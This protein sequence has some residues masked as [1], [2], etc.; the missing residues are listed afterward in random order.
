MKATTARTAA[1][2]SS[3][4][5][6]PFSI[7]VSSSKSLLAVPRLAPRCSCPCPLPL[8][9]RPHVRRRSTETGVTSHISLSL[10]PVALRRQVF[11]QFF[12]RGFLRF[13]TLTTRALSVALCIL[14]SHLSLPLCTDFCLHFKVFVQ[15][16]V[17]KNIGRWRGEDGR[18]AA[19]VGEVKGERSEPFTSQQDLQAAMERKELG[20][21]RT[22][23]GAARSEERR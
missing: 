5:W 8:S 1:P 4:G 7:F 2:P 6:S 15:V 12:P 23:E 10:S 3:P 20:N 22:R 11:P 17:K 9:L 18:E 19:A 14:S 21:G 16:R 13:S